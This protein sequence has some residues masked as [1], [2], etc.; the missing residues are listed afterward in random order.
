MAAMTS[1]WSSEVKRQKSSAS[2][3]MV[4]SATSA[5]VVVLH[6][7][8]VGEWRFVVIVFTLV[9]YSF[10]RLASDTINFLMPTPGKATVT[11]SS[12]RVTL[13]S[14]T[15]PTPKVGCCTLSRRAN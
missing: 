2:S 14:I 12:S 8:E 13:L 10:F 1:G 11:S 9:G 6:G 15:V 3:V 7:G 4:T 5:L